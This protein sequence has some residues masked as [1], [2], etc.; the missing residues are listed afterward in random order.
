MRSFSIQS[1]FPLVLGA[2]FLFQKCFFFFYISYFGDHTLGQI[3]LMHWKLK[4][5]IF[6]ALGFSENFSKS[7]LQHVIFLLGFS[8][9]LH[10]MTQFVPR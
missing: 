10:V 7:C 8:F 9:C 4:I 5:K 3:Y 6:T 1:P 2:S